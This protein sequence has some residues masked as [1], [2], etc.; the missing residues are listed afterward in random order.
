MTHHY[1]ITVDT[2][3]AIMSIL[4]NDNN[5][6]CQSVCFFYFQLNDA[7]SIS[8]NPDSAASTTSFVFLDQGTY[9]V[10]TML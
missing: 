2:A 3:I 10:S 5:Y 1:V 4:Y 7:T 8:S 9:S 6:V